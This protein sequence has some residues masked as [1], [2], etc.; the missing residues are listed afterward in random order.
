MRNVVLP[1]VLTLCAPMLAH[2]QTMPVATLEFL[3][4]DDSNTVTQEEIVQQMDLLFG[5]MD[6][7][8]NGSLE[9]SE[10]EAFMSREVF[11]DADESGNGAISLSEYRK[12]VVEDFSSADRDGDGVL[13]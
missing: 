13:D 10:V 9:F 5:P 1:L 2:A 4:R 8:G 12:Q 6:T 3:D 11:D 7:N